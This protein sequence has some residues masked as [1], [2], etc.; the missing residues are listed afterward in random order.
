VRASAGPEDSVSLDG[1]KDISKIIPALLDYDFKVEKE[2]L[3]KAEAAKALS[4]EE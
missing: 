1:V 2:V 3:A 4:S